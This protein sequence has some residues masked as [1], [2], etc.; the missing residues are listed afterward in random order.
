MR[1]A[2]A[3]LG[4]KSRHRNDAPVNIERVARAK[5]IGMRKS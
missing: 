5:V 4:L 2:G 1:K 3:R